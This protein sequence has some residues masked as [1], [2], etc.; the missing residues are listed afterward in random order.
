MARARRIEHA[1]ADESAVQRFVARAAARDQRDL[2]R[3]RGFAPHERGFAIQLDQVRMRGSE[4][5]KA[6]G[7]EIVDAIDE[8][9]HGLRSLSGLCKLRAHTAAIIN[10]LE[11]APGSIWPRERSPR[12]DA[13]PFSFSAA[14]AA[15]MHA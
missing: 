8:F 9:L 11:R 13:R 7:Q 3:R 15:P 10:W 1:V 5:R 14:C 6:F 12:N 2:A 4:S